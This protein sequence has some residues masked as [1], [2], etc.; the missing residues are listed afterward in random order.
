MKRSNVSFP[1]SALFPLL[2]ISIA[3]SSKSVNNGQSTS[4]GGS[5]AGSNPQGG[6]ASTGGSDAGSNPQGASSGTSTDAGSDA[7]TPPSDLLIDDFEDGDNKPLIPG[8]WYS[9]TDNSNGGKSILTFTGATGSAIV[10]NGAGYQSSRSLEVSYTFDQGTY[11]YAPYLGFGASI[12][13]ITS[14]YDLSKYAG[15]S[16]TYLGGAH[17]MRVETSEVT[18]Y[19]VYGVDVP[20]AT[21]WTTVTLPFVYFAQQGWGKKVDFNLSHVLTLSFALTGSTGATGKLQID[22]LKVVGTIAQGAPDMTINP[23]SPPADGLLTSTAITNPLQAKAATYL[24]RGYNIT[25][26]LEAGK[27]TGF[28]YDESF[29]TKL[30]LA[31]FKSL[32]L[33]IDLDLY[34]AT[35]SGTG[36]S[37]SITV[38]PDLFTILD[39]FNT[40]T[41]AHGLSLTIDYHQYTT[42][43]DLSKPDTLTTAIQLWGKVAEHF[44]Y[45]PREDI[46]F[47]LLNEP[48]LSFAGTAPTQ[49]QWTSL[50]EQMIAAIRATDKT[51]SII[52]GDVQWYGIGALTSRV[53]LSDA[54]VVYAFHD[55]DPFIFTHQ[56]ASWANMGSTHDV[57]YPYSPDRWA[58][59]YSD[60]GFSSLMGAWILNQ[61]Q[62]YYINGTHSA[63]RNQILN[64]KR[65]AVTN[66]VPVICNEFG[67]Y[68]GSSRLEDRVRY[69]ADVVGIF[70]ELAIPWQ[71][72]FMLMNSSGTVI[73]EYKSALHL[74][75]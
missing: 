52:F 5:D 62:S 35:T 1:L 72:W 57:P 63:V 67:A 49:T 10:M 69:Y 41:K 32:R 8:G 47:E 70:E 73:P 66:N 51:H 6:S 75:Q 7:Q 22:N 36:S 30:S 27:F 64:A 37:L 60:L 42:L 19:D 11:V 53:P 58:A 17:R 12:G 61:A 18:D 59:Y 68:D 54:N 20:A 50:A 4:T 23:V 65:W 56:G 55:Y 46:F 45:E 33:P 40:W 34:V 9:Y 15:I 38:S 14:P 24:T 43:L 39:S 25:N 48:E 71:T 44:A 13:P 2:L 29:V 3:C 26:W 21:G 16:Y 28:T 74:G 31:G